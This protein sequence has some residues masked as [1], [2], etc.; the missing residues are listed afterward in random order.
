MTAQSPVQVNVQFAQELK[1]LTI[2]RKRFHLPSSCN[3][4]GCSLSVTKNLI[5]RKF[6]RKPSHMKPHKKQSVTTRGY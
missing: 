1:K 6:P 5:T 4:T 2:A 3:K